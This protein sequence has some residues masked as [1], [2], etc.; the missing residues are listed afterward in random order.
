M[1]KKK[2]FSFLGLIIA[3]VAVF[4]VISIG[5]NEVNDMPPAIK[6]SE[7][8]SPE[9]EKSRKD[10]I[11]G[12]LTDEQR[13]SN[14]AIEIIEADD[15]HIRAEVFFGP[16]G[17]YVLAAK[18]EDKWIKAAEGNGIPAC[19]SIEPYAFPSNIVPGCLSENG[20]L[21]LRDWD[22]IK[23]AIKNCEVK[24]VMQSH[25]LEVVLDMKNGDRLQAIEPVIDEV[26]D[27]AQEASP[28]CGRII[29]ATE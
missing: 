17:G 10:I 19:Q 6:S 1:D 27:L 15:N 25:S 5:G 20:T 14:T 28:K 29:M 23:S 8:N 4:F 24:G 7:T 13:S 22:R 21:R 16:G 11:Q 9:L 3:V 18:V 2:A 26:M 12:L